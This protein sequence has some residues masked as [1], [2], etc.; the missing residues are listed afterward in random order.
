LPIICVGGSPQWPAR[1]FEL[2]PKQGHG[3][4]IGS[5][6][7]VPL[8]IHRRSGRRY[9]F[10][11][12]HLKPVASTLQEMLV[13]LG[14]V[15]RAAPP[16]PSLL[17]SPSPAPMLRPVFISSAHQRPTIREWNAQHD[18]Q[19]VL[20]RFVHLNQRGIGCCPFGWHHA[21]GATPEHHSRCLSPASQAVLA[22][23]VTRGDVVAVSLTFCVTGIIWTRVN[24][25]GVF[26]REREVSYEHIRSSIGGLTS[27]PYSYE[28]T[29]IPEVF[30][31]SLLEAHC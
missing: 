23:I 3:K 11:G 7:R 5:L 29:G 20:G 8:G 13:W 9:P 15:E 10:V 22:G 17:T 19:T 12:A 16:P 26:K 25:G 24:S 14:T 1:A 6:I 28:G 27:R 18:P 31:R 30:F 2:Y 4:G 21:G